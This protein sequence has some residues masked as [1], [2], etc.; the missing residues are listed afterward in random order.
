MTSNILPK[1]TLPTGT[2]TGCRQN[3]EEHF[4]VDIPSVDPNETALKI[5]L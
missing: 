5:P 3:K 4:Q 2:N 1:A